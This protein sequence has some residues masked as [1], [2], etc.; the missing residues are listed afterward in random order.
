MS[1]LTFL[2]AML[3]ANAVNASAIHVRQEA[4]SPCQ[5]QVPSQE[6]VDISRKLRLEASNSSL[7]RRQQGNFNIRVYAH[8]VFHYGGAAGG[9][10]PVKF[11]F[12]S[13]RAARETEI[14][15]RSI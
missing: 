1:L 5:E 10:V 13:N 3:M 15:F 8:V 2:V 7:T 12:A 6:F 11:K 9:Y 4:A 14:A